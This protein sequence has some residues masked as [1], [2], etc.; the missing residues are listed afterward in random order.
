MTENN[1]A[2]SPF[3]KEHMPIWR[4]VLISGYWLGSNYVWG[5]LLG[6]ML[7]KHM[8]ILAPT[9]ASTILSR[10]QGI[11]ALWAL[12]IPLI[13]GPLSDRCM[14]KWGRRRPYVFWGGLVAVAGMGGMYFGAQERSLPIVFLAYFI[15]QFGANTALASYSGVIPDLVPESE[16]GLASGIM[17]LMTQLGTLLGLL[18]AGF[19]FDA[20]QQLVYII[21]AVVFLISLALTL[22]G[23]N[24]KP[25]TERPAPMNWSAY[26]RSLID[27]LRSPDF[28]WVWITRAMMMFGFYAI[29]PFILFFVED[30]I[31]PKDATLKY[32]LL[33]SVI[34]LAATFSG[35]IGGK[36]SD[37]TGRKPFV[38]VSSALMAVMALAFPFCRNLEQIFAVGLV[39]GL[40]YG[41]YISV[42]WALGTDVL[43]NKEKDAAKDMGVWHVAMTLPQQLGVAIAGPI[44]GLFAVTGATTSSSE[45]VP[46][47]ITGYS[48]LFLMASIS[49]AAGAYFIK[50]VRGVR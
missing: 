45:R 16:H 13:A 4:H 9:N 20:H 34:L 1:E 6:I 31:R 43:P 7:A 47:S 2:L 28:A 8:G 11:G 32:S 22:I 49:F 26:G 33:A 17:A 30:V 48:I 15:L 37:K 3:R 50:N 19:L 44:L 25:L 46:Y 14:S 36:L 38:Y 42:D 21:L 35:V 29:Q 12:V 39:F 10:L 23:A 40:G 24:E 18:T 41:I 27:P 5:A